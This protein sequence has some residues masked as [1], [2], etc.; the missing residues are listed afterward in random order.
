MSPTVPGA[1]TLRTAERRVA[2]E[3][4]VKQLKEA[5][6]ALEAAT[7]AS[8]AEPDDVHTLDVAEAVLRQQ[9]A[10]LHKSIGSLAQ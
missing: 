2:I 5:T 8:A 7:I 6:V 3:A 1:N 9:I 4:F 10:R